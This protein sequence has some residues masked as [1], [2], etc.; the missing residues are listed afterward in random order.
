MLK[1]WGKSVGGVSE[2]DG[3]LAHRL[4][5]LC[6]LGPILLA[7]LL[8][9]IYGLFSL[10]L[11]RSL[12]GV[13]AFYQNAK[14]FL[15]IAAL[16]IPLGATF[17]RIHSSSQNAK[18]I[19]LSSKQNNFRNGIDHAHFFE[20]QLSAYCAE[21]GKGS[22]AYQMEADPFFHYKIL[23]PYSMEGSFENTDLEAILDQL[24]ISIKNHC[25]SPGDI[26]AVRSVSSNIDAVFRYLEVSPC[27]FG[28]IQRSSF[29]TIKSH[30]LSG[31]GDEIEVSEII[32]EHFYVDY[33]ITELLS[34]LDV[35]KIGLDLVDHGTAYYIKQVVNILL[36]YRNY[37]SSCIVREMSHGKIKDFGYKAEEI[38]E[39]MDEVYKINIQKF[40]ENGERIK[41]WVTENADSSQL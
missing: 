4:F 2:K 5:W 40:K 28:T 36:L 27:D 1:L 17:A 7:V 35:W 33:I 23:F 14:F 16:S 39:Y 26:S 11:D 30:R 15:A 38:D 18:N 10:P 3:L 21:K 32:A 8:A 12:S 19:I 13:E 20:E 31:N 34:P 41:K 37:F 25:A 6:V 29:K 24:L 9:W 22:A